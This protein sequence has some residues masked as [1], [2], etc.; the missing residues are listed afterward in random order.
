MVIHVYVINTELYLTFL[1]Y[2]DKLLVV[3]SLIYILKFPYSALFPIH[4]FHRY[5][6]L[7]ESLNR[8]VLM[9]FGMFIG[10]FVWGLYKSVRKSYKSIED[11]IKIYKITQT[12]IFI[13]IIPFLVKKAAKKGYYTN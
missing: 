2:G 1:K 4:F 7:N 6:R 10:T 9:L 11:F 3:K 13:S 8:H 5:L 12:Q